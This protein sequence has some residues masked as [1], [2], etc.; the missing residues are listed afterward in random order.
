MYHYGLTIREYREKMGW[1][2]AQL[3]NVWPRS[4]G[5]RGVSSDYVSL[6][7]T[8]KRAID[9]ISV[10]RQ[11]C[12]ILNIPLWKMGLSEYDPFNETEI[13]MHSLVDMNALCELIQDTWY[14]RLYMPSEITEKKIKTLTGIFTNLLT[15][16]PKLIN[17]KDFV[18][19]YAQVK[20][21]QEVVY[22]E[23]RDYT[24]SLKYSHSMLALAKKAGDILTESIA[25]TRVGVELLRDENREALDYLEKAR[26]LSFVTSSKEVAA[27]CYTFLARGY[28]TFGDE[29]RFIR[30][31]DTALT[32]A[33]S[34]KGLP[35]T[36][37]DHVY[38]AYS[39]I[40]E[41]KVNGLILF[42]KGKEA[43][44]ELQ[45]TDRHAARENNTYLKMWLP[46]DYAQ[47]FMLTNE[48]ETSIQ[49]LDTFYDGI[50][51]YTSVRIH[52]TIGKHLEQLDNAGY[53]NLPVVK[54]F[55]NK[56]H[57]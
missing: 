6:V 43:L 45:E 2:Q 8:G 9:D 50:K 21:L 48:I 3:G 35:I 5:D 57:Y 24:R 19:L 10:L 54:R 36:T 38:H 1:T 29:K 40:V 53:A 26:D 11:L 34:M 39:A 49:W 27:Y 4:N 16:Y 28:A 23:R 47:S 52:S 41:E 32:L 51:D 22:T 33:D 15:T 55:K 30:A 17:N 46:L 44:N 37:K 31:I 12:T 7:E 56:I 20:R 18:V 13:A 14:I 42:G 25:M